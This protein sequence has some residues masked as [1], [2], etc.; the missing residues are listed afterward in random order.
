MK[1][2]EEMADNV[3]DQMRNFSRNYL[4]NQTEML[5]IKIKDRNGKKITGWV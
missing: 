1:N 3:C 5:E 4:K 2:L